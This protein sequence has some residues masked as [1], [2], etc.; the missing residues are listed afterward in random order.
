MLLS[1]SFATP[2]N[3]PVGHPAETP[4][5]YLRPDQTYALY[6]KRAFDIWITVLVLL[7]A[8]PFLLPIALV[9]SALISF[10]G[11]NPIFTQRRIGRHGRHFRMF[12]FRTMVHNADKR[13]EDY[14]ATNPEA[15]EEWEKHQKLRFD[16]RITMV[17]RFLRKTSLDELPQLLNVLRGEMSLVGP[18]PMM[19]EQ[20]AFYPGRA[21]YLTRP[22]L[23]GPWQVS[24]RHGT[25]F[26][27][28]AAYDDNYL[29]KLSFRTDLRILFSTVFVV[30][31]G[32]GV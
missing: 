31:K 21:Y 24:D 9:L 14:L 32:T 2:L 3:Q 30:L 22:G 6:Y 18:R 5:A 12:K 11:Y 15:R 19:V 25:S 8:S 28:R 10:D 4:P 13:L 23:T 17:G 1:D 20:S 29:H 16:P 7:L 26:V 27:D